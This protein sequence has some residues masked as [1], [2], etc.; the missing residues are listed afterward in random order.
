LVVGAVKTNIDHAETAA[1]VAGLIK[2]ALSPQ[3]KIIPHQLHL[4]SL[5]PNFPP[6]EG[7]IVIP[8]KTPHAIEGTNA[9]IFNKH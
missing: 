1:G 4:N 2:V 8:N 6:L 7:K 5:N 3:H 9:G